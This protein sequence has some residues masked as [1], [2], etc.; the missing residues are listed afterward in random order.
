MKSS[1]M[2]YYPI[3]SAIIKQWHLSSEVDGAKEEQHVTVSQQR[4]I[5]ATFVQL[6]THSE[7]HLKDVILDEGRAD[8]KSLVS[9]NIEGE[10]SGVLNV[11]S[12]TDDHAVNVG[13]QI[14]SSDGSAEVSEAVTGNL[15][16]E[17]A[18]FHLRSRRSRV[19]D[20]SETPGKLVRDCSLRS[21]PLGD[22]INDSVKHAHASSAVKAR[23]L[24]QGS[25]WTSYRNYY[26]L[27]RTAS[28]IAEELTRKSS[29]KNSNAAL[30]SVDEILLD[31]MK[32]ISDKFIEF[33]WPNVLD[34]NAEARKENC[35]WCFACKVPEDERECLVS[36][37][38]NGPAREK[39]TSAVLG[40]RSRKNKRSHLVDVMCHILCTED[41]LQGLLLGP[42]L[43]PQ[44][45]K[46][47]HKSA[48]RV[49][50][51]ASV[52]SMLLKVITY[53]L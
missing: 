45:S 20:K 39:F 13:N 23:I 52:K 4:Q 33:C 24:L 11:K 34:I 2:I 12:D 1:E 19:S 9:V 36:M 21:T 22:K 43:N 10:V 14:L 27:A 48:L 50:S 35:G 6:S 41:R 17:K 37:F 8:D 30:I 31:Q 28:V 44:Y 29:N 51:I 49:T 18:G 25:C 16:I 32:A 42:W 53:A 46:F 5:P 26:G 7:P 38:C 3:I 47:W 40:I 15:N